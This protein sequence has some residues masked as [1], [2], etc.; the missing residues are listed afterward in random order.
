MAD[1]VN[2]NK[3]PS[4]RLRALKPSGYV[5]E[6]YEEYYGAEEQA[7]L[8]DIMQGVRAEDRFSGK[9]GI[10][11]YLGYYGSGDPDDPA[12]GVSSINKY[13]VKNP[14]D[15]SQSKLSGANW[16]PGKLR[17][18]PESGPIGFYNPLDLPFE[19]TGI[20]D[21]QYLEGSEYPSPGPSGVSAFYPQADFLPLTPEEQS[22]RLYTRGSPF[23]SSEEMRTGK[24]DLGE[25][26]PREALVGNKA[27]PGVT[28][29]ELMHRGFNTEA[30]KDFSKEF[31]IDNPVMAN[32]FFINPRTEAMD[33]YFQHMLIDSRDWADSVYDEAKDPA[34]ITEPYR[35]V[36]ETFQDQFLEWLTPEKQAQYGID[37]PD[38]EKLKAMGYQDGGPVSIP[39]NVT[40]IVITGNFN[41]P[42]VDAPMSQRERDKFLNKLGSHRT[43]IMSRMQ[44]IDERVP[45]DS[46]EFR[47]NHITA[48]N[49]DLTLTMLDKIAEDDSLVMPEAID[50]V[51]QTLDDYLTLPFN[52]GGAEVINESLERLR[53]RV[54]LRSSDAQRGPY[55]YDRFRALQTGTD[56]IYS[57]ETGYKLDETPRE[58]NVQQY[59]DFPY[60][61]DD[62]TRDHELN[63]ALLERAYTEPVSEW[64]RPGSLGGASMPGR[65]P[66]ANLVF[67][68]LRRWDPYAAVTPEERRLTV[69]EDLNRRNRIMRS[70]RP[71]LNRADGGPVYLANG[72]TGTN[73]FDNAA[74]TP[75]VK[76]AVPFFSITTQGYFDGIGGISKAQAY[77][78][79]TAIEDALAQ[80]E[81]QDPS[82]WTQAQIDRFNLGIEN[83]LLVA[84][85]EDLDNEALQDIATSIRQNRTTSF[86]SDEQKWKTWND[87]LDN[88]ERSDD[89]NADIADAAEKAI[90]IFGYG[91]DAG[92][93]AFLVAA[94]KAGLS[95]AQIA[96]ATGTTESSILDNLPDFNPISY[97]KEAI[98]GIWEWVKDAQGKCLVG[99]DGSLNCNWKHGSGPSM[100]GTTSGAPVWK[101]P[102]TNTTVGVDVGILGNVILGRL[103]CQ[104]HSGN[105]PKLEDIPE[106]ILGDI[107]AEIERQV[108]GKISDAVK[109]EIE[110][111]VMSVLALN[112][113]D[114]TFGL[115]LNL[116]KLCYNDDGSIDSQV[117]QGQSC[118]MGTSETPPTKQPPN[119]PCKDADGN[120]RKDADGN[121]LYPDINGACPTVITEPVT[122]VVCY[123]EDATDGSTVPALAEGTCPMGSS[124]TDPRTIETGETA[125]SRCTSS[126]GT[127]ENGV[128]NCGDDP[129]IELI[130]GQ[131]MVKDGSSS[132]TPEEVCVTNR[133]GTATG[134]TWENGQCVGPAA[135]TPTLTD[136]EKCEANGNTWTTLENGV[137]TCVTGG[138]VIN[139]DDEEKTCDTKGGNFYWNR[140]NQTCVNRCP[141]GGLY[142]AEKNLCETTVTGDDPDD[143][144]YTTCVG[145][146][147]Y[148]QPA[149]DGVFPSVTQNYLAAEFKE[150]G[151]VCPTE[152]GTKPKKE[153]PPADPDY[154]ACAGITDYNQ[155]AVNN[156]Y[157]TVTRNY[158]AAEFKEMGGVCPAYFGTKPSGG[159]NGTV[160]DDTQECEQ[161][162]WD[163][164]Q[165]EKVPRDENGDCPTGYGGTPPTNWSG[166]P[167][168]IANSQPTEDGGCE[169]APGYS[170][171][172]TADGTLTACTKDT[173]D[174][175]PLICPSNGYE[176]NGVCVCSGGYA[177]TYSDD[178]TL[179]ACTKIDPGCPTNGEINEF[180]ECVCK[181]GFTPGYTEGVLT[182]CT[183][184]TGYENPNDCPANASFNEDGVCVCNPGYERVDVGDPGALV[185]AP[186]GGG[187]GDE[188]PLNSTRNDAGGCDCDTGYSAS[189]DSD[190]VMTCVPDFPA[191]NCSNPAW[192]ATHVAE[193]G[194]CEDKEYAEANPEICGIT[195]GDPYTRPYATFEGVDMVRPPWVTPEDVRIDRYPASEP[196]T[197][198]T[199][200]APAGSYEYGI[201]SLARRPQDIREAVSVIDPGYE[202]LQGGPPVF[203]MEDISLDPEEQASRKAATDRYYG[204]MNRLSDYSTDFNVGVDELSEALGVPQEQFGGANFNYATPTYGT[205]PEGYPTSPDILAAADRPFSS[206]WLEEEEEEE[207]MFAYGGE[208]AEEP[209]GL[210]SLLQRRQSAVNTMLVKRGR[211]NG[212]Q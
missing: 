87:F 127:Y 20:E 176:H 12:Y 211:G 212:V 22:T 62:P 129:T 110:K 208:V 210:E 81:E 17:R 82:K 207:S 67:E 162:S 115:G 174:I 112:E 68:Q 119:E 144:E 51:S 150:M 75:N 30:V 209:Q 164:K 105:C 93:E 65:Y 133:D 184:G 43:D 94:A 57:D 24:V 73:I 42:T 198:S 26:S 53:H 182:S 120:T 15:L 46:S 4:R 104:F 161:W 125:E 40:E 192:A 142:N 130:N 116:E 38:S 54:P 52:A 114:S 55:L 146:T 157:P 113:E 197:Y 137:K 143:P 13:D 35:N 118:P 5:P 71:V 10:L 63:R 148:N 111:E 135:E 36:L 37:L 32:D 45:P 141:G 140:S 66:Q 91:T 74:F 123:V 191:A 173:K 167:C 151:G 149:V 59:K 47:L 103:T 100:G 77:A 79:N 41:R 50:F 186:I 204:A 18:V 203:T 58:T 128:C 99:L 84:A 126:G 124:T 154:T 145:I 131:C 9:Y 158:L 185:C 180:G 7:E 101:I 190:G 29:H 194:S 138:R 19:Y 34:A 155:P 171:T 28:V 25:G 122:D 39:E 109:A 80:M 169:C 107:I 98:T 70:V 56:R 183:K 14:E 72:G 106:I 27:F 132:R 3:H 206:P 160:K 89:L 189:T 179:I 175:A 156:V 170:P 83:N 33:S 202:Q 97:A 172:V 139:D 152:F 188:C 95:N 163:T 165:L 92:K 196:S 199:L 90:E 60:P 6:S 168:D 78:M 200:P 48:Q 61:Q 187:G 96:E 193:C 11:P 153:K 205:P 102:G 88:Y 136:Q 195:D 85:S 21:I 134:N 117:L 201:S 121:D 49:L 178:N 181:E 177:P 86:Q 64:D 8:F 1:E 44:E 23:L 69:E 2:P 31:G 147:D 108:K 16:P 166:T 76:T 159:G